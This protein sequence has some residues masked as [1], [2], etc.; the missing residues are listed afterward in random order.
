MSNPILS[1]CDS[2][3]LVFLPPLNIVLVLS[4]SGLSVESDGR[5]K[6]GL[7]GLKNYKFD[8]VV[9]SWLSDYFAT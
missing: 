2:V 3:W 6:Y 1:R 7:A 5:Y 4:K 9:D 8:F